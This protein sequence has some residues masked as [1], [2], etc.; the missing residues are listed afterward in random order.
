MKLHQAFVTD[1]TRVLLSL[2]ILIYFGWA[3]IAH[4]NTGL[5]E[6][7]KNVLLIVVGFWMG[8]AKRSTAEPDTQP[9]EEKP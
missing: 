5:E 1:T 7:L 4:W 2:A 6:A 3:L 9:A 8:G